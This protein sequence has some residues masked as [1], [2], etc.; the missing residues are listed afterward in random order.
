MR[1]VKRMMKPES[2]ASIKEKLQVLSDPRDS[3]VESLR[4]DTRQ[5][6][7]KLLVQ[8]DKKF[9]KVAQLAAKYEE[10]LAF[11]REGY[12]QGYQWIAGID[13]VGRG[14]LAGP[15]VSA[16]VILPKDC[17]ILG[18]N[19]SKQVSEKNRVALVIEIKEKALGIGIGVVE[20]KEIDQINIYQA[21]KKAMIQAVQSLEVIPDYLLID[22]M[23]LPIDKPQE[24]IIKGDARSVSIAAA[25]IIAKVYRDELMAT[26]D[27]EFPGYGF[28][29][30][31]GYGTKE[32]LEGLEKQ[33]ITPIHRLSFS[34]VSKMV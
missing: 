13:E 30:N 32:H 23:N 25:S 9:E 2:I 21:S 7:Q 20:P 29:R 24:K 15:V 11:E 31:A 12:R 17:V 1:V 33:G 4:T 26:Y 10:M 19:D 16:A 5:G 34:P 22:A 6:V 3:F 27:Q 28:A 14:P 18:L 8:F